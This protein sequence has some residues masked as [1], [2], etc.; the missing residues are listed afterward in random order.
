MV[1]TV[2]LK[3]KTLSYNNKKDFADFF[4]VSEQTVEMWLESRCKP[5]KKFNIVKVYV[6]GLLILDFTGRS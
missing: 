3:D 2:I 5:K 4:G 6:D 1:Y